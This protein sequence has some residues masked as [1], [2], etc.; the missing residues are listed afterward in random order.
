[1]TGQWICGINR[2]NNDDARSSC[3]SCLPRTFLAFTFSTV[4]THTFYH[5]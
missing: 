4:F 5:S 3:D 2:V 1:M